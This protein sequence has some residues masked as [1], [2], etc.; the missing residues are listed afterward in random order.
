MARGGEY[1]Y[2]V[3]NSHGLDIS[4]CSPRRSCDREGWPWSGTRLASVS[5]GGPWHLS[6]QKH[7]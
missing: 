6:I 1:E 5:S 3:A 4:S 2:L 7:H